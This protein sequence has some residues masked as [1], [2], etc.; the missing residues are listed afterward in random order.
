MFDDLR[1]L[2]S[3]E[4]RAHGRSPSHGKRPAAF[5]ASAKGDNPMCGDRVQV[6]VR[7]DGDAVAEAGFE[8]RGCEITIASADL[9]CEAVQGQQAHHIRAMAGQVAEM[10]RTGLCEECEEAL[11]RLRPLSAVHEFP[12]RVK[13][14]TLPWH[15]LVAALDGD[16]ETTS[17]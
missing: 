8:A 5:D 16:K 3:A 10:A 17:E 7:R 15:A 2:Y 4:I 11:Q 12:S 14:V 9:M 13:C 6:F 1:D